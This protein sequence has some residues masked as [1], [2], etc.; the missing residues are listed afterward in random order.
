MT[1]DGVGAGLLGR[2]GAAVLLFGRMDEKDFK[3][4]L[5]DLVRGHHHPEEHDWEPG[6]MSVPKVKQ[7]ARAPGGTPAKR[8]TT[9]K[10]KRLSK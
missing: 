4:H 10:T 6:D 1:I 2:M 3:K 5:Q 8:S 9:R 7:G